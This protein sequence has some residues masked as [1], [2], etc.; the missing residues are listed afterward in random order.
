MYSDFYEFITGNDDL[1]LNFYAVAV[2]RKDNPSVNI[3]TLK[4]KAAC[5]P[6]LFDDYHLESI[7][8]T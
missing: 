6:G 4:G 2:A 3:N 5:L 8:N 1:G 7:L